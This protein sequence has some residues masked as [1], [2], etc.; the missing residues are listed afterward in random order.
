MSVSLPYTGISFWRH[1]PEQDQNG[2]TLAKAVLAFQ[3]QFG[4]DLVKITP[5]STWQLQDYGFLSHWNGNLSGK[6]EIVD[7][8]IQQ[9]GKLKQKKP[10]QFYLEQ[11]RIAVLEVKEGLKETKPVLQT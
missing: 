9:L 5:A 10:V 6:R 2:K 3:E 7:A 8:S 4:F 11:A 1:F